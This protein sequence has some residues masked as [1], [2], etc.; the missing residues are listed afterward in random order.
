MIVERLDIDVNRA[1]D[2]SRQ[3]LYKVY[4]GIKN[5]RGLGRRMPDVGRGIKG[6][7]AWCYSNRWHY[8]RGLYL[9]GDILVDFKL[10]YKLTFSCDSVFKIKI[11]RK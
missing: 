1:E 10:L 2:L 3:M 8:Y 9:L 4:L 7:I 6:G 5:L 11:Y